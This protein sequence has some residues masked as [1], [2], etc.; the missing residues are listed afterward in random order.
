MPLGHVDVAALRKTMPC[1]QVIAN[2]VWLTLTC[3]S[4]IIALERVFQW[5]GVGYTFLCLL[6]PKLLRPLDC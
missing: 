5:N 1:D 3:S 2:L 6:C 4:L